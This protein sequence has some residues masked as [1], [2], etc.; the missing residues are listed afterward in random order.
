MADKSAD[1][2]ADTD[3]AKSLAF[4]DILEAQRL[5]VLASAGTPEGGTSGESSSGGA[6]LPDF[7]NSDYG[8]TKVFDITSQQADMMDVAAFELAEGLAFAMTQLNTSDPGAAT[9][10]GTGSGSQGG[11]AGKTG[12]SRVLGNAQYTQTAG[13]G[14]TRSGHQH[15]GIDL[16]AAEGTDIFSAEGGKVAYVGSDPDGYGNYV[17]VQHADGS[18]AL[19]AHMQGATTLSVGSTVTA[20]QYLGD[21]GHSGYTTGTTGN[22]LH[23]GYISHFDINNWTGYSN[24][25][26]PAAWLN[27]LK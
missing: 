22:H 16:A 6:S 1:Y 26:D 23:L 13:F 27:G 8:F 2:N 11:V 10:S 15:A 12:V 18:A 17:I 5:Q 19:Y 4:S 7:Y 20:G 25:S 9:G 21:V 14:D 3:A 24:F